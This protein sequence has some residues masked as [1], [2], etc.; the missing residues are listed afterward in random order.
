MQT[1]GYSQEKIEEILKIYTL[2][3]YID[4]N[5]TEKD[6]P[7]VSETTEKLAIYFVKGLF[8]GEQQKF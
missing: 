7:N 1:E 5:V 6:I 3:N 2:F 4:M 8:K